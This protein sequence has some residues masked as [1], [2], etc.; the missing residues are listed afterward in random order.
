MSVEMTSVTVA[1]IDD[2]NVRADLREFGR[3]WWIF[4]VAGLVWIFVSLMVL[5]FDQTSI[6]TISAIV[7]IVFFLAA[8]EEGLH[9]VFVSGWRWLHLLLTAL[10]IVGGVWSFAYSTM[11]FGVLALLLGWFFLIGGTFA[12]VGS[13]MN[14]GAELWWLELITGILMVAVAFWAVGDPDRSGWLLVLWV[15]LGAFFRGL[16]RIV[17]AFEVRSLT[18]MSA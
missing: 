10:F 3:S 8:V 15:G 4:L 9:A 16:N 11:T 2:A 18:R 6:N 12:I 5:Q 14:R 17:F 7:G 13:L 1:E